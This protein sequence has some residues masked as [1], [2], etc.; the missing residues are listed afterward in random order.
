MVLYQGENFEFYKGMAVNFFCQRTL[1][2]G[3]TYQADIIDNNLDAT[4]IMT[5]NHGVTYGIGNTHA[6]SVKH[7]NMQYLIGEKDAL[8]GS[9]LNNNKLFVCS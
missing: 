5:G 6:H 9:A 2:G 8:G 7:P 4:T 3:S 1:D